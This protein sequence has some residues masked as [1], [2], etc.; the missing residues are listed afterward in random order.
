[1]N[2]TEK[3]VIKSIDDLVQH[4]MENKRQAKIENERFV[5]SEKFKELQ[6]KLNNTKN[7]IE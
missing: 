5:K 3:P 2:T 6:K 1:M 4:M 7:I